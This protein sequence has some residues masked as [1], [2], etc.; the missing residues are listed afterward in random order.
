[1]RYDTDD[2]HRL[3][4]TEFSQMFMPQ[5]DENAI[6]RDDLIARRPLNYTENVLSQ[7]T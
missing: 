3:T 7:E 2:D 4:Y 1:M 5:S 6:L